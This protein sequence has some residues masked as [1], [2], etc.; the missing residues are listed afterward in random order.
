MGFAVRAIFWMALVSA[1][2]PASIFSSEGMAPPDGIAQAIEQ[3][4]RIQQV[5]SDVPAL[6][7]LADEAGGL[8]TIAANESM[9]RI[10]NWL[11]ER[12]TAER[13]AS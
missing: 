5:C 9:V 4:Q 2:A 6:C 1:F 7:D 3:G 11:E 12:Q 8:A 13:D 10:E